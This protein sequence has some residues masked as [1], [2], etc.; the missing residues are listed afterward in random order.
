MNAKKMG[1]RQKTER[2]KKLKNNISFFQQL[3]R[4]AKGSIFARETKAFQGYLN[5]QKKNFFWTII[6]F[7]DIRIF[8]IV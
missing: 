8:D 1:E 5:F 7:R 3:F 6:Y 4:W 2:E